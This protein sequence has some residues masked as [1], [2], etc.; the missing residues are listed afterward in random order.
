MRL[1]LPPPGDPNAWQAAKTDSGLRNASL[2]ARPLVRR[3]KNES[4]GPVNASRCDQ[5]PDETGQIEIIFVSSW[6]LLVPLSGTERGVH[7]AQ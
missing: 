2:A 7:E 1:H 4:P 3:D 5:M 6:M